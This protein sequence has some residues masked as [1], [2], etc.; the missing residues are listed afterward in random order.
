MHPKIVIRHTVSRLRHDSNL[1]R[2]VYLCRKNIELTPVT[3]QINNATDNSGE[4]TGR[5]LYFYCIIQDL[6]RFDL[7]YLIPNKNQSSY[8]YRGL[9]CWWEVKKNLH[10]LHKYTQFMVCEE[11]QIYSK[12]N[13]FFQAFSSFYP[14]RGFNLYPNV[15]TSKSSLH[16]RPSHI[17]A[18]GLRLCCI[19]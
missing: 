9:D 12:T 13:T 8:C 18:N 3:P 4:G 7:S 15:D 10:Y 1:I 11:V 17:Q 14:I 2:E 16:Y 19:L 5:N 6:G